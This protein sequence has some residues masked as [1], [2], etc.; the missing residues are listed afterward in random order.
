MTFLDLMRTFLLSKPKEKVTVKHFRT[1]FTFSRKRGSD[2]GIIMKM[3]SNFYS[4][5][6][7][8]II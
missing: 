4:N 5:S 1:S 6:E 2:C 3:S 7:K 8:I